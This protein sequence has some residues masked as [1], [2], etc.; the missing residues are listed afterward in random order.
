MRTRQPYDMRYPEVGGHHMIRVL[1]IYIRAA[2]G[3]SYHL[4]V[5]YT[6]INTK[7]M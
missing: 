3:H 1:H 6:S 2:S 5:P 7:W 4:C